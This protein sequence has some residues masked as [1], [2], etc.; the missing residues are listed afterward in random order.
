[1]SVILKR[2]LVFKEDGKVRI[3]ELLKAMFNAFFV[4]TTGAIISMYIFCLI[5]YQD[6]SFSLK[7][8]Q[9]ILMV[10]I[11]SDLT[12]FVFY[13]RKDLGKKQ[14]LVRSA[15]H[16]PVVLAVLLFFAN[17]LDWVSMNS[18]R[19]LIVFILLVLGVYAGVSLFTGYKDKKTADTLNEGLKKRYH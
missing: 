18:P 4:I 13:S 11:A 15:I 14:M 16:V 17:L 8:I 19:E 1:M 6:A 2:D 10:A 9:G 3:D 5:F 12:F 7:D